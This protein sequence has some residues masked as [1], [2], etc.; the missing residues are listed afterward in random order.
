MKTHTTIYSS[1]ARGA[2]Y[3]ANAIE[4]LDAECVKVTAQRDELLEACNRL[5]AAFGREYDSEFWESYCDSGMTSDEVRTEQV[6][7]A[8]AAIAKCS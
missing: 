7:I 4:R 3:D 6:E 5:V 8:R 1:K 2:F